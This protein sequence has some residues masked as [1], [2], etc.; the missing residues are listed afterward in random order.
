MKTHPQR[1]YAHAETSYHKAGRRRLLQGAAAVVALDEK[2]STGEPSSRLGGRLRI[3]PRAVLNG[4][5]YVLWT[6]CQWK[7]VHRDRFGM[8]SS[9]LHERFQTWQEQGIWDKAFKTLVRFY[10]RERHIQW[11]AIDSRSCA[12][13]LGG[14]DTGKN[15][16]DRAKLGSK[17]HMLVDQQ[18]YATRDPC[19][20]CQPARQAGSGAP[21]VSHR[22]QTRD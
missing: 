13:P 15:P 19:Q 2:A 9:V 11:Q 3:G 12:A 17:I 21:G 14:S 4:I 7:A 22:C 18:G 8:S 1:G 6:G 5:W 16:M 10:A 20:R